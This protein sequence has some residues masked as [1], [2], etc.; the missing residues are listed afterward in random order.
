M[1]NVYY[2]PIIED[3][4]WSYSRI[5]SFEDCP[6]RWFMKYI[7]EYEEDERFYASYGSFMHKILE[8]YYKKII[9]KEEMI[10]EYL[11]GFSTFVSGERPSPDIVQN[12][13]NQ[14]AEYLKGFCPLPYQLMGIE[15]QVSFHIDGIPF[16]GF[17]DY[18]GKNEEGIVIVDNKSRNLRARSGRKKPTAKD[19]E[20]DDML[21]Q[22][23]LYA[24]G[25]RQ[26]YGEAP[27]T[28]CFNCFRTGTLIE[29][30]F[31]KR[32]YREAIDWAKGIIE[33][34]MRCEDEDFYPR[35]DY[36]YCRYICG[37]SDECV[38]HQEEGVR[39]I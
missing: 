10:G 32:A 13:I 22:L 16:V 1:G 6:Y 9:S 27:Q 34:I 29:E 19:A 23:Y 37:L 25:V 4:T 31:Q 24:E 21:K 8:R 20:L 15:K 18:L 26:E 38:Y 2:R 28:L 36:F 3:M 11:S 14:G 5:K 12:Y 33:Q 30:P 7:C 35:K 39:K 17:I